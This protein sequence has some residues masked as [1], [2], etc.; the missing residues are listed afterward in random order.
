MLVFFCFLDFYIS[1][2]LKSCRYTQQKIKNIKNK[3][4]NRKP[5]SVFEKSVRIGQAS[6]RSRPCREIN[7]IY[8]NI[9]NI[10][11]HQYLFDLLRFVR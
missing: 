7:Q 10:F 9:P 8:P 11:M 4:K 2:D 6:R 3:T 5:E 1:K